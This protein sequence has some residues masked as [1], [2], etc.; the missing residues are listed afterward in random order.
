M[1]RDDIQIRKSSSC[2]R[3]VGRKQWRTFTR[4]NFPGT[5]KT[6]R[7]PVGRRKRTWRHEDMQRGRVHTGREAESKRLPDISPARASHC[8]CRW[9]RLLINMASLDVRASLTN[10]YIDVARSA[11]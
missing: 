8:Q 5:S 1:Q 3:I 9:P 4:A 10:F 6:S 2:F 11:R 7:I